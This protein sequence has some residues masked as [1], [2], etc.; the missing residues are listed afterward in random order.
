[1]LVAVIGIINNSCNNISCSSTHARRRTGV[2]CVSEP[3]CTTGAG[4]W[5][6]GGVGGGGREDNNIH[7]T[8]FGI[9]PKTLIIILQHLCSAL[10]TTHCARMWSKTRCHKHPCTAYCARMWSKTSCHKHLCFW[11]ACP[12]HWYLQRFCL[13]VQHTVHVVLS[14]CVKRPQQKKHTRPSKLNG[15]VLPLSRPTASPARTLASRKSRALGGFG[16]SLR[17]IGV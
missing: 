5:G 3:V 9:M 11:R 1:M 2:L 8:A 17:S 4:F 12:N 13:F 15:S 7:V 10:C 6:V 16:G 14:F